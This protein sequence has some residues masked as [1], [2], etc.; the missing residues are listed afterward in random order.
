[1]RRITTFIILGFSLASTVLSGCQNRTVA[2]PHETTR[3]E[4]IGIIKSPSPEIQEAR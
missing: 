1:M 2:G 3:H 4:A